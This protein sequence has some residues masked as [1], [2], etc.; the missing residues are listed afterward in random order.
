MLLRRNEAFLSTRVDDEVV[1]L[2]AETGDF[3][4]LTAS[5]AA[6]W[7]MLEQPHDLDAL[8]AGLVER[9]DVSAE[10]CRAELEPFIAAMIER[11]A[12]RAEAPAPPAR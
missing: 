9:F 12:L 8:C 10:H 2:N 5:A 3:V 4:G 11:G 7:D 1:V 6:A